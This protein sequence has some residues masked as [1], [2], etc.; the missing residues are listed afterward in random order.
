MNCLR[1]QYYEVY[2]CHYLWGQLLRK[3]FHLRQYFGSFFAAFSQ[4]ISDKWRIWRCTSTSFFNSQ[5]SAINFSWSLLDASFTTHGRLLHSQQPLFACWCS[6][7]NQHVLIKPLRLWLLLL[8]AS[9][10]LPTKYPSDHWSQNP[11]RLCLSDAAGDY[12]NR[13]FKCRHRI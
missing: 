2:Y 7:R 3:T 5:L 9:P 1:P 13:F 11:K 12:R 6:W 8:S 4:A 10:P